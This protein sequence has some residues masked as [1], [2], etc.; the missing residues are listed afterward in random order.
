HLASFLRQHAQ[1]AREALGLPDDDTSLPVP[2]ALLL[3]GGVFRGAALAERLAAVLGRW[4]GQPLRVLH[5]DVPDV[6][7]ARGGVAYSLARQGQAPA[8]VS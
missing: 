6:A 5:N 8:I 1:A 3:N 7:V 2:D 4:R